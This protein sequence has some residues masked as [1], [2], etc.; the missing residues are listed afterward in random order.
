[1]AAIDNI[2]ELAQ[3]S[4]FSINGAENDDTGDDLTIFQNN[5]IRAFNMWLDEYEAEAY[6]NEAR[7][8]DYELG[9]IADTTDLFF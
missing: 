8:N 4:Y 2:T 9:V 1:M 5:Y 6:W 7:E 3:D